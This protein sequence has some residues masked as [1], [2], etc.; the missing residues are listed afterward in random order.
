[1]TIPKRTHAD[2]IAYHR[3]ELER[4]TGKMVSLRNREKFNDTQRA[5]QRSRRKKIGG[6]VQSAKRLREL[7]E[8]EEQRVND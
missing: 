4:L 2:L 6:I 3:A 1:M 7:E 5:L 8:E